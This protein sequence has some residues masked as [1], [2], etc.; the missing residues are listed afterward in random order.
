MKPLQNHR[1]LRK[2][3]TFDRH[4]R[5]QLLKRAI[6]LNHIEVG[7]KDLTQHAESSSN[8]PQLRIEGFNP[9]DSRQ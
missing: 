2:P 9:I 3:L 7:A 4:K 6:F 1:G 5:L 8:G